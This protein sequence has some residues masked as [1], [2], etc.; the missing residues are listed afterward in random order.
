MRQTALTVA[1]SFETTPAPRGQS[2]TEHGQFEGCA[3]WVGRAGGARVAN[4][5]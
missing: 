5:A 2:G 1:L 3:P 4:L